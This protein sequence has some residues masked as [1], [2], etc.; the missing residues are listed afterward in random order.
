MWRRA[1]FRVCCPVGG[2]SQAGHLPSSPPA[3]GPPMRLP[4]VTM[5]VQ[6]VQVDNQQLETRHPVV[7]SPGV[8]TRYMEVPEVG[9]GGSC[10]G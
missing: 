1:R 5:T 10:T 9:A 8:T 4:Q 3:L 7:L 2:V 6:S